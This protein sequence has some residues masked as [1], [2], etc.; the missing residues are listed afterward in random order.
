MKKDDKEGNDLLKEMTTQEFSEY[1]NCD[2]LVTYQSMYLPLEE[3]I[4]WGNER[5]RKK[6]IIVLHSRSE[7]S[8]KGTS[9]VCWEH[10]HCTKKDSPVFEGLDHAQGYLSSGRDRSLLLSIT[11]DK[12]IKGMLKCKCEK[13]MKL[14]MSKF[15]SNPD[16][17]FLR[18][19][20]NQCFIL[21]L[22][23]EWWWVSFLAW[24]LSMKKE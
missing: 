16:R 22:T 20:R 3:K 18:C 14:C 7:I 13:S 9:K 12:A 21:C 17:L 11:Q 15:I 10:F 2:Y 1:R 8:E 23:S 6:S 19:Q 24:W 4:R 5:R